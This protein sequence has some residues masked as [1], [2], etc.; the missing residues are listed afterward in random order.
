MHW[1]L[2]QR[3]R[4]RHRSFQTPTHPK[5]R[6]ADG[7]R[8]RTDHRPDRGAD[9]HRRHPYRW[10][11][12]LR[13]RGARPVA[14]AGLGE[15]APV[16]FVNDPLGE[17]RSPHPLSGRPAGTS[18]QAHFPESAGLNYWRCSRLEVGPLSVAPG[19]DASAGRPWSSTLGRAQEGRMRC[20][21]KNSTCM[22][23]SARA[24]NLS[25]GAI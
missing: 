24:R 1:T 11:V 14:R 17:Y 2:V 22:V 15:L 7:G 3:E 8:Q 16:A 25:D 18:V 9:E 23:K 6:T 12:R 4:H 19:W 21:T 10:P 20:R 5:H 13:W